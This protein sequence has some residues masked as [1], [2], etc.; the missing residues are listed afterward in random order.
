MEWLLE[1]NRNA[2]VGEVRASKVQSGTLAT[3]HEMQQSSRPQ[4]SEEVKM[5]IA[6]RTDLGMGRGK[7]AAQGRSSLLERIDIVASLAI[8]GGLFSRFDGVQSHM[9]RLIYIGL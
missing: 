7:V 9:L 6:V 8:K 3:D 1:R 5:V 4:Q 2:G